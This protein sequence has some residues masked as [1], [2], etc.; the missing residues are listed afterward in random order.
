M[1]MYQKIAFGTAAVL[2]VAFLSVLTFN[3]SGLATLVVLAAIVALLT[4]PATW[5]IIMTMF[6]GI[7]VLIGGLGHGIGS[8]GDMVT[9]R[10][11]QFKARLGHPRP[12]VSSRVPG[13]DSDK[14]VR[15]GASPTEGDDLDVPSFMD[16][17]MD[18]Q[19]T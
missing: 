17:A 4:L 8:A 18:R 19:N 12:A 11:V 9:D 5:K 14:L 7:G 6:Q 16:D 10:S 1:N 15:V 13:W 3:L 2:A